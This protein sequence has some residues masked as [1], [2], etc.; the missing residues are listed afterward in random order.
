M[1][2][3]TPLMSSDDEFHYKASRRCSSSFIHHANYNGQ[4]CYNYR[5]YL[6]RAPTLTDEWYAM[7]NVLISLHVYNATV[8]HGMQQSL[9]QDDRLTRQVQNC[10]TLQNG[11]GDPSMRHGPISSIEKGPRQFSYNKLVAHASQGFLST[12]ALVA[13]IYNSPTPRHCTKY[14]NTRC[15]IK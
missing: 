11:E 15:S 14:W 2:Q 12:S 13:R 6:L 3:Y 5:C 7:I 1:L 9:S 4:L 10:V 8:S